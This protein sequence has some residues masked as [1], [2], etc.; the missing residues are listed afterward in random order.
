MVYT[1]A[2][3]MPTNVCRIGT[4]GVGPRVAVTKAMDNTLPPTEVA[5]E[6]F[7]PD[8]GDLV[9]Q[10]HLRGFTDLRC[11][12]Y[13]GRWA[14]TAYGAYKHRVVLSECRDSYGSAATLLSAL[15]YLVGKNGTRVL[16][17]YPMG[18][19]VEESACLR[20]AVESLDLTALAA[21]YTS[22][23]VWWAWD[24]ALGCFKAGVGP[25]PKNG[26]PR[27]QVA[28]NTLATALTQ[29]RFRIDRTT[30]SL[31]AYEVAAW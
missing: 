21:G 6:L 22:D 24:T 1:Y 7:H 30:R 29:L 19:F 18:A 13:C 28:G 16:L 5:A 4:P 10:A 12:Q 27:Y 20:G 15:K 26:D 14:V 25:H 2:G 17:E 3:G 31:P 9:T 11:V 8:Y 23:D